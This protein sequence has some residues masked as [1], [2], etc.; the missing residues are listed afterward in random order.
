MART[1]YDFKKGDEIVRI[2]PSKP[3]PMMGRGMFGASVDVQDKSYRGDKMEFLGIANGMIYLRNHSSFHKSVFGDKLIDLDIDI[4]DE[5][6]D[7]YFDPE[8]FIE[9]EE[10]QIDDSIIEEQIRKAIEVEDYELA[11]KLK[12][13]LSSPPQK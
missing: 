5:G 4:W 7:Y 12:S 10:K 11:E 3:Y 8:K 9:G 13:K 1:I 6:W 2:Q